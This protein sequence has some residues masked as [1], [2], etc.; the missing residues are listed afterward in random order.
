MWNA[1]LFKCIVSS[2]SPATVKSFFVELLLHQQ[3]ELTLAEK[4]ETKANSLHHRSCVQHQCSES[5]K[6]CKN[7]VT[8]GVNMVDK[9]SKEG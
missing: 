7:L 4:T 3:S 8:A 9:T 6:V 1:C 2:E 5:A